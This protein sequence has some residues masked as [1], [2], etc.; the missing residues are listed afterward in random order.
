MRRWR[1]LVGNNMSAASIGGIRAWQSVMP[2]ANGDAALGRRIALST[3]ASPPS[4][5]FAGVP[6][7]GN[8]DADGRRLQPARPHRPVAH[9][10]RIASRR[11]KACS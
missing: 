4:R 7:G 2:I 1:Q 5:S 11:M 3:K 6:T 8:A 9:I 10:T